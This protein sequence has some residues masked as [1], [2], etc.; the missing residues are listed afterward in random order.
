LRRLVTKIFFADDFESHRATQIDVK[1]LVGDTHRTTTQFH[2][3]A[4]FVC[5]QLV[6]FQALRRVLR[7]RIGRILR[8]RLLTGLNSA[9]ESP[10]QH[11]DG[12]KF[13]LFSGGE[14]RTT[15]GTSLYF[16]SH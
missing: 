16:A 8:K 9:G 15:D 6:M 3:L 13:I 2:R 12:T 7:T 5:H 1:R 4:V 14:I 11:A 10:S